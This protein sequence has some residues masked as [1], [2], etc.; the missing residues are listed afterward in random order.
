MATKKPV[1]PKRKKKNTS[2][3]VASHD[4]ILAAYRREL[5]ESAG[6]RVIS[7][8][9]AQDVGENCVDHSVRL[10][11]VGHSVPVSER[12]QILNFTRKHCPDTP[13]LQLSASGKHEIMMPRA[14]RFEAAQAPPQ[15]LAAVRHALEM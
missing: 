11:M 4:R 9:T 6:Y 2:V 12:R 1:R 14:A 13:V 7:V 3:L 5:L 10:V 8:D 15:I